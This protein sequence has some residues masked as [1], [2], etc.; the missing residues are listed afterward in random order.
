[1]TDTHL[2]AAVLHR[3]RPKLLVVATSVLTATIA[4][5]AWGADNNTEFWIM[6]GLVTVAVIGVYGFL[7]PRK[8]A[9]PS[10]SSTALVLSG[11]AA[12]LV[13]PAFWS[14]LPMVLGLAGAILG[15]RG[16]GTDHGSRKSTVAFVLGILA[17]FTYIS[18]YVSDGLAQ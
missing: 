18:I 7:L 3:P 9:Q 16:Q 2:Q 4:F 1:M 17:V 12:A 13:M 5:T 10:A 14:G 11:I 6:T 8:L 15:Y